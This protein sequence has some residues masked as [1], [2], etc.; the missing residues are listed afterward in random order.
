M[1]RL[2]LS[3]LVLVSG[4]TAGPE[5]RAYPASR[6]AVASVWQDASAA[7]VSAHVVAHAR[8]VARPSQPLSFAPA[9]VI[10]DVAHVATVRVAV[11][12]ARE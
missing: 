11:D 3:F 10:R 5:A 6:A 9:Q 12:R 1:L 2:L 7:R 4:L 8:E